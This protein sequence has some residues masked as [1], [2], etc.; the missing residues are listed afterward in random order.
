[1]L[2]LDEVQENPADWEVSGMKPRFRFATS[3][4]PPK[5]ICINI[6]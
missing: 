3:R 5:H 6:V 1:M 2:S 4:L